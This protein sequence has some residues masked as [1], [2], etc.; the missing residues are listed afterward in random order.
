M[1]HFSPS[2]ELIEYF[3]SQMKEDPDMASAVAAIRTLLEF[4]KTDKGTEGHP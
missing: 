3:K 2:P 1:S 4:L